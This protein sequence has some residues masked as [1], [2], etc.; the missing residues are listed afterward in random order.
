MINWERV[1]E[2][3]DEVGQEDFLE[4]VEIFLEEVDEVVAR[5]RSAPDP[6]TY[7]DDLHF[8][9]GSAVNLG[10]A[11]LSEIC[12]SGEKKAAEGDV[13]SID[14]AA[15]LS[16]YEKSKTQFNGGIQQDT[17]VA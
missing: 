17:L 3:R 11:A 6:T 7:E 13:L 8:L 10:F 9:K 15:V 2:L 4:V 14:V 16:V 5:L 12:Q 1:N